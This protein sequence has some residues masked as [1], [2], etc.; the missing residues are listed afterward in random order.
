VLL[1]PV[2]ES[3]FNHHRAVNDAHAAEIKLAAKDGKVSQIQGTPSRIVVPNLDIDLSIVTQHYS[4]AIKSWPVSP[5]T[6]NYAAETP[7]INNI[8]GQTLIYGHDTRG[9]FGPLSGLSTGDTAY[10]YTGNGHV[11][12]YS[13]AGSRDISPQSVNIISQMAKEP[14]GLNLITCSGAY[15]QYRHLMS[16]KL[17]QAS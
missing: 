6:A 2:T 7:M 10:V 11:F 9:I 12:K 13:Y 15:F 3:S 1:I 17:L 8:R 16:F 5:S 4:P 14:A